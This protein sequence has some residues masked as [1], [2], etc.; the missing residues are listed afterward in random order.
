MKWYH[1]QWEQENTTD[2][3][4][5]WLDSGGGKNLS[6]RECPRERLENERIVYLSAEQR[7]ISL[8]PG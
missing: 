1:R 7:K 8:I 6:L 2:N 3:F 4:F 5:R